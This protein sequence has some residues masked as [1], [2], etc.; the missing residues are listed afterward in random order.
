MPESTGATLLHSSTCTVSKPGAGWLA[1][2]QVIG[3]IETF[4]IILDNPGNRSFGSAQCDPAVDSFIAAPDATML[5]IKNVQGGA[6]GRWNDVHAGQWEKV[7][8]DDL[9]VKVRA[10]GQASRLSK[11]P[12]T[13]IDYGAK[14]ISGDAQEM[15][16]V[17]A[18]RGPFQVEIR[19][20][21]SPSPCSSPSPSRCGSPSPSPSPRPSLEMCTSNKE[22]VG[23]PVICKTLTTGRATPNY[24]NLNGLPGQ[25]QVRFVLK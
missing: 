13:G 19:R 1:P 24:L 23:T 20:S 25:P 4:P 14:W 15:L 10:G 21:P 17:L 8:E 5:R 9:V 7:G 2:S 18:G 22:T 6:V 12:F 16:D 11:T 3:D